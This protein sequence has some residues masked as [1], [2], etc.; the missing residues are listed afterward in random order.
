MTAAIT[1][2]APIHIVGIDGSGPAGLPSSLVA[3][4]QGAH[5]FCGGQRQLQLFP[6]AG[7]ERFTV[8]ADLD[9]LYRRLEQS[10]GGGVVVLASGDPCFFGLGPLLSE[11]FGRERVVIHPAPSSVSLAFARLGLAWQDAVVLSAHG[12]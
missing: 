10:S 5:I 8:T 6:N 4:V 9:A 12:R 1:S 7:G 3:L 2:A 11:R